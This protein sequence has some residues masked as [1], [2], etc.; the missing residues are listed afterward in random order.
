[1]P[2]PEE[3]YIKEHIIVIR[4]TT[5]NQIFNEEDWEVI[6]TYNKIGEKIVLLREKLNPSRG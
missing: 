3:S 6:Q 5:N 2:K 4:P 1:M